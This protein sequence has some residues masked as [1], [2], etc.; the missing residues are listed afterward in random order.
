MFLEIFKMT[1]HYSGHLP[2]DYYNRKSQPPVVNTPKSLD[3]PAMNTLGS[4]AS[5][6]INKLGSHV[7]A[8][9]LVQ[10]SELFYTKMTGA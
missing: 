6:V 10:A 3:S 9:Y 1:P 7:F 4:L 5:P 8:V 2:N